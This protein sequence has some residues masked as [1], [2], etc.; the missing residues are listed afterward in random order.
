MTDGEKDQNMEQLPPEKLRKQIEKDKRKA[1]RST[2]FAVAALVALIAVCIAWFVYNN[3]VNGT[4]GSIS[5]K[6]KEPFVLASVGK[7]QTAESENLD[8]REGETEKYDSYVDGLT[9]ETETEE[10]ATY[11][12]GTA[13]LAWRL[14]SEHVKVAPGSSGKVEFYIIPKIDGLNKVTLELETAGYSKTGTE[15]ASEITDESVKNLLRGHILIFQKL[16]N[17]TGYSGWMQDGKL[18][19]KPQNGFKKDLPY[20][21]TFYWVWPKYFRNYIYT[22]RSMYGDLFVSTESEDYQAMNEFINKQKTDTNSQLFYD[23]DSNVE[24]NLKDVTINNSLLDANLDL[25]SDYYNQADEQIGQNVDYLW[26]NV[27]AQ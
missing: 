7:R 3:V 15:K 18:E 1:A 21:V 6:N 13:N 17:T 9:G 8:L 4:T 11:Y 14:S 19:I 16:D 23:K 2:V 26:I 5:A 12:T 27:T 24:N 10:K 25:C 20:K 22:F